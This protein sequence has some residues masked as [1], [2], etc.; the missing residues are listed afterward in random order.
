V[1][2]TRILAI[3]SA[4][5]RESWKRPSILLAGW[6][7]LLLMVFVL[8]GDLRIARGAPASPGAAA[9]PIVVRAQLA[10]RPAAGGV[11]RRGRV[12]DAMGFL[13][14]GAEVAL[15]GGASV[16][17]DADGRFEVAL[18]AGSSNVITVRAPGQ[19]DR[20][21]RLHA[22]APDPLVVQLSPLAPW[23]A[24]PA[25][26]PPLPLVAEGRVRAA[27]GRPL[28]GAEVSALG[29]D[30]RVCTDDTGRYLL[31]LAN[32]TPTLLVQYAGAGGADGGLSVRSEPLQLDRE[33]GI[34][35]VPELVAGPACSVGGTVRD[36]SGVPVAGVPVRLCGEG[37]E[38]LAETGAGGS[39][40][41]GG[42]EP[43]RYT[44]RPYAF[45][46][47]LGVPQQVVV[48][49]ARVDC[50]LALVPTAERAVR[51]L[52]TAGAPVAAAC[53]ALEFAGQRTSVQRADADGWTQVPL[54]DG[55]PDDAWRFDVRVGAAAAPAA[56]VRYEPEQ[57]ALVVALH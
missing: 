34:V 36:A 38:L 44:L 32:A 24:A 16:R 9:E 25:P 33:Q 53:V 10:A 18:A 14:V 30:V 50:E 52:D 45:R 12:F 41:I 19:Q 21:L 6:A 22:S 3:V 8:R 47:A 49:R 7:T 27:D 46:G 17:T 1:P 57:G 31:P 20:L 11:V 43:G 54:A 29:G 42:L 13:V 28:A 35:P 51:V 48:D 39:F 5:L 37:F 55:A 23:D 56:A 4:M 40:R 15:A 2:L 26:P